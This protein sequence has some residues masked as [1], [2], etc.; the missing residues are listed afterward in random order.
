MSRN[1]LKFLLAVSLLLNLSVM[2]TAG[3]TYLSSRD[4]WTSPYGIKMA[5]NRFLFEELSLTREQMKSMRQ[6]AIPFRAEVDRQRDAIVVLRKELIGLLRSDAPDAGA[7]DAT[8][9]RISTL[10]ETLQRQITRHMLEQKA[11]LSREQQKSFLDLIERA[12]T[13]SGR[14]E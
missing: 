2:A 10:Q 14:A 1:G 4:L 3:Y 7:V 12:M 5:R 9:A 11:L 6:K 13:Q 8:I